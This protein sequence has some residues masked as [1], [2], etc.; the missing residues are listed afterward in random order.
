MDVITVLAQFYFAPS[1]FDFALFQVKIDALGG[2]GGGG[3]G[4][5]TNTTITLVLV[6][7]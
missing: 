4:I 1:M 6:F 3:G 7:Y 5:Y 2:G